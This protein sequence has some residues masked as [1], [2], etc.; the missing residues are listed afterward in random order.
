MR[1]RVSRCLRKLAITKGVNLSGDDRLR[2][3]VIGQLICQFRL[4]RQQFAEVWNEDFD[5]YFADEL[6]RLTP[7]LRDEL[8]ADDGGELRVQPAGRLLIRAICQVFDH[9]RGAEGFRRFSKII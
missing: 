7:M 9:Y 4:D 1:P 5:R 2:R 8:I 3:W 6:S